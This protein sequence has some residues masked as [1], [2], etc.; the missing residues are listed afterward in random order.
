MQDMCV[1]GGQGGV[2]GI[3]LRILSAT[4]YK[5]KGKKP[6]NPILVNAGLSIT[7][8]SVTSMIEE[9]EDINSSYSFTNRLCYYGQRCDMDQE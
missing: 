8:C 2:L 7:P 1:R 4:G 3:D 6:N 9:T 5:P